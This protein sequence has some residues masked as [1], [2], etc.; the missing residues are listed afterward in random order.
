ME[1]T[2]LGTAAAEGYPDPFCTCPNCEAARAE[3]GPSLR[4]HSSALIND[5]LLID[6]GPHLIAASMRHGLRLNAIPY[7]I[8]THPHNDHL[9]AL[10][11]FSRTTFRYV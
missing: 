11:F 4:L 7:A 1:L 9:D 10:T 5:D 3:G 8:Q 2:F 6:L